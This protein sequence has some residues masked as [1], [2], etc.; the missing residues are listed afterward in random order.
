[1]A[2]EAE[3]QTTGHLTMFVGQSAIPDND[4]LVSDAVGGKV[5]HGATFT[6]DDA[7][8]EALTSDPYI[9]PY[10][11]EVATDYTD[12]TRAEL[13]QAAS[14]AG[15]ADPGDLE[16][17]PHEGSLAAAIELSKITPPE[18]EYVSIADQQ[19]EG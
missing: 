9:A 13:E 19:Q 2:T 5:R 3:T 7:D 1:M 16:R 18:V 4:T 12:A 15:I 6:L 17:Y 11:L 14:D 10:L 8:Y